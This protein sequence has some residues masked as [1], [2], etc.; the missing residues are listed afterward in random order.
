M[1]FRQGT[2]K[3]ASGPHRKARGRT[4][5]LRT[6][7]REGSESTVSAD[8]GPGQRRTRTRG[9]EG[10]DE[11][12]FSRVTGRSGRP[13]ASSQQHN[14]GWLDT[15]S[16]GEGDA[17][18]RSVSIPRSDTGRGTPVGARLPRGGKRARPNSPSSTSHARPDQPKLKLNAVGFG[19]TVGWYGRGVLGGRGV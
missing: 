7:R 14:T 2:S 10:A 18:A 1:P 13:A 4:W 17:R 16:Q 9:W 5:A 15:S 8:L 11:A 19:R 12:G 3:P 6:K